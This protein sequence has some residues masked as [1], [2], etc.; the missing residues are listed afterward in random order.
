[1]KNKIKVLNIHNDKK[2]VYDSFDDLETK[3]IINAIDKVRFINY[4]T[5]LID[6][7]IDLEN[8]KNI[9]IYDGLDGYY[10]KVA[11]TDE[12]YIYCLDGCYY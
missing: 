6:K 12:N 8:D 2:A 10:E 5:V 1:M 7:T 11:T 9:F 4:D 3:T